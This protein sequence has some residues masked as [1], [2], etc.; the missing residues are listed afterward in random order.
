MELDKKYV[1]P[2]CKREMS[3]ESFHYTD[4]KNNMEYMDLVL[5]CGFYDCNSLFF[6]QGTIGYDH[7]TFISMDMKKELT[8]KFD[9]MYEELV[10]NCEKYG[11]K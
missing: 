4:T 2:V 7:K 3:P 11:N 1:C 6:E 10:N 9:S 8:D 5:S